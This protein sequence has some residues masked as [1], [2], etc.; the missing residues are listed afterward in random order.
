MTTHVVPIARADL[1]EVSSFLHLHMDSRV[2]ADAWARSFRVTERFTPPNYGMKL[3]SGAVTVGVYVAYYSRRHY[4]DGRCEQFCNLGSW[5]VLPQ[6]R[7]HGARM[8][9]AL[10]AQDGFHF[11]D[12]TPSGNVVPINERL[13]FTFLDDRTALVPTIPWPRRAD[14]V[15]DAPEDVLPLLDDIG[16]SVYEDHRKADA[17]RQL[18]LRS[19]TGTCHVVFRLDRRS[20]PPG[21]CASILHVS[22]RTVFRQMLRPLLGHL[23]RRHSAV[24]MLAERRVVG[25][26]PFGSLQIRQP[27]PKMYR[28][29]TLNSQDI[30]YLY[31]E[32]ATVQW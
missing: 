15:R 4:S 5:V 31:T 14:S 29:A 27:Q 23:R 17:A 19:A 24:S 28:S 20:R 12:L 2:T 11:V 21:L 18:L 26:R 13:G 32:L 25:F 30:D 16:R 7:L 8:L 6:Y 3:V 1:D 9:K 10:L 22:N